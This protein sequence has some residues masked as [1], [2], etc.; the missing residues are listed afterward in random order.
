MPSQIEQ[1]FENIFGTLPNKSGTAYEQLSAIAMYL[2]KEGEVTHDTRLRGQFSNSIY[3]I[4]IHHKSLGSTIEIMGEAKDYSEQGKKVG[5]GD[6]QKL[7]GALPD[8]KEIDE[9]AFFSS[10]GYTKPAKLY[11]EAAEKITGGKKINLYELAI[12]TEED[13]K[14][15]VK[16]IVINIHKLIADLENVELKPV[17]T[18][19]GEDLLNSA[20]LK[21]NDISIKLHYPISEFY[22][23]DRSIKISLIDLTSMGYGEVHSETKKAEACYWLPDHYILIHGLL[24]KIHGLEYSMPFSEIHNQI[25]ISDDSTPRLIVKSK[26]GT[27]LQIITDTKLQEFTFD[28]IRNLIKR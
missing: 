15:F 27:P 6:I 14:N 21:D 22:N 26:D 2:L 28:D 3:Q 11:A 4:D 17:F 18:K 16:T 25:I 9:G 13:E 5:R 1:I 23:S 19:E 24:V 8:I 10:T 20:L 12:S 7:G